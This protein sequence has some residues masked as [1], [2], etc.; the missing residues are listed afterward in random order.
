MQS[1]GYE[2]ERQYSLTGYNVR[3]PISGRVSSDY[4]DRNHPVTG[5]NAFHY[6]MDIVPN[7]N[8]RDSDKIR[9]VLPGIIRFS[10]DYGKFGNVVLIDHPGG[11]RSLYAHCEELSVKPGM[12]VKKGDIIGKVGSTGES[13]GKHLHFELRREGVPIDPAVFM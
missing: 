1:L 2:T 10:G 13:T 9:S 12:T 5:E 11:Y 4:G 8:V 7:G 6:G 3:N